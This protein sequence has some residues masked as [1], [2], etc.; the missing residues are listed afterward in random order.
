MNDSVFVI[1]LTPYINWTILN[2][3]PNLC[4]F[5]LHGDYCRS[6]NVHI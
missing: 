1:S 6:I 2:Y 5:T 3:N 4:N